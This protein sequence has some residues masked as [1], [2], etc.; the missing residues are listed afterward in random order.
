MLT[1]IVLRVHA[2]A[3]SRRTD[4][5]RYRVQAEAYAAFTGRV[6]K[7]SCAPRN[8]AVTSTGDETGRD[9]TTEDLDAVRTMK[10]AL[11]RS[12]E[13]NDS[14]IILGHNT[15]AFQEA[16]GLSLQAA[17]HHVHSLDDESVIS[18]TDYNICH[19]DAIDDSTTIAHREA[20]T[21]IEDTQLAYTAL[22][23]QLFTSS[24]NIPDLT[25]SR[26]RR[27]CDDH[28]ETSP[29]PE[30]LDRHSPEGEVTHLS[31]SQRD[32]SPTYQKSRTSNS[33]VHQPPVLHDLGKKRRLDHAPVFKPF[34][35]PMQR[36]VSEVLKPR[37]LI[38]KAGEQSQQRQTFS[39]ESWS[40]YLKTPILDRTVFKPLQS[41]PEPL[42]SHHEPEHSL[43]RASPL[44]HRAPKRVKLTDYR[45]R[46]PQA[47][48]LVPYVPLQEGSTL[49]IAFIGR[50][51]ELTTPDRG[52]VTRV[53][54]SQQ[55]QVS[56]DGNETTSELPSSYALS[57]HTTQSL[58][59]RL[60]ASQRS[61]SDPGPAVAVIGDSPVSEGL[62][63]EAI[64]GCGQEAVVQHSRLDGAESPD[65]ATMARAAREGVVEATKGLNGKVDGKVLQLEDDDAE[66]QPLPTRVSRAGT[67]GEALR[68]PN[69]TAVEPPFS[70]VPAL[71]TPTH[72]AKP[73]P[74]QP[75]N[76]NPPHSPNPA[77]R[78][79]NP[80][81]TL[82]TTIHPLSPPASTA[83]FAT[84]ITPALQFLAVDSDIPYAPISTSRAIQALE[85]G[86]WV[87]E[88]SNWERGLQESF[89]GFLEK[90]VGGG[91]AGWGVW[92]CR[93][94]DEDGDGGKGER[95]LRSVK[96]FCWGEV[97]R[98]VYLLLYVASK[99]KVRKAG[100][101]WVDGG[102]EVVVRMRGG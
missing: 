62:A 67:R 54:D 88:T 94:E 31:R 6:V 82:P 24:L 61:T 16:V 79:A 75:A 11:M 32:E 44:L 48:P 13:A 71:Q 46:T 49:G 35:L 10:P 92:C 97:V 41:R 77:S 51:T 91:E 102:G 98:H 7:E 40:S 76:L 29:W 86:C 64:R 68:S 4:D 12:R 14:T 43:V 83:P 63:R 42:S 99:S 30:D 81:K 53:T 101:R 37:A 52:S 70:S 15:P 38:E 5:E 89:W 27:D 39:Q 28:E 90:M 25:P 19:D 23:S 50:L 93:A 3:P 66:L 17:A 78:D 80:F 33:P 73:R 9:E 18:A 57:E 69:H 59:A 84:H 2:G 20:P 34:K 21:F 58:R 1:K 8:E 72:G 100:L 85:R 60:T 47:P 96:V 74:L 95:G 36:S 65:W 56:G 55:S 22:E 87:I 45:E 26:K